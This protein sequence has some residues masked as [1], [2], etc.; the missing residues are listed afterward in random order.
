M[1][2]GALSCGSVG[3]AEKAQKLIARLGPARSRKKKNGFHLVRCIVDCVC[4]YVAG[5]CAVSPNICMLAHSF[6]SLLS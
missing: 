6:H 4:V 3:T 2:R 1:K 5:L